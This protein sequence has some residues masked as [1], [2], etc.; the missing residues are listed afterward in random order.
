MTFSSIASRCRLAALSIIVLLIASSSYAQD[1]NAH[2]IPDFATSIECASLATGDY[3]TAGTWSCNRVPLATDD[4]EIVGGH[5]VTCAS[6][7]CLAKVL[8]ADGLLVLLNNARLTVTTLQQR[9]TGVVEIGSL[10]APIGGVNCA[11]SGD[12]KILFRA[13]PLDVVANGVNSF[14]HAQYGN[15]WLAHGSSAVKVYGCEKTQK[16]ELT[17]DVAAGASSMPVAECPVNWQPGDRLVIADT[18]QLLGSEIATGNLNN[19]EIGGGGQWE[20]FDLV[21]CS[22]ATLTFNNVYSNVAGTYTTNA[23]LQYAHECAKDR[24]NAIEVSL[25]PH[26]EN[27]TRKVIFES[28]NPTTIDKVYTHAPGYDGVIESR[29]ATNERINLVAGHDFE[30]GGYIH[31]SGDSVIADGDY[32]VKKSG[33]ASDELE[34]YVDSR[35]TIKY[36]ITSVGTSPFG[37]IQRVHQ[38]SRRGHFLASARA[39]IDI[40]GVQFKNMGRTMSHGVDYATHNHTSQAIQDRNQARYCSQAIGSCTT[41]SD[42]SSFP[43]SK[44]TFDGHGYVQGVGA[45]QIGRYAIHMHKP[46]GPVASDISDAAV[47]Y[48]GDPVIGR[49]VQQ[50]ALIN[51]VI[52]NTREAL[53]IH[54]SRWGI[55]IHGTSYGLIKGNTVYNIRGA[56]I[57]FEDGN[58]YKNILD[59]NFVLRVWGLDSDRDSD[60]DEPVCYYFR[61]TGTYVRNNTCA[62]ARPGGKVNAGFAFKYFLVNIAATQ[63]YSC[64]PGLAVNTDTPVGD[65]DAICEAGETFATINPKLVPIL[66]FDGNEGYGLDSFLTY[67]HVGANAQTPYADELVTMSY[68]KNSRVWNFHTYVIYNYHVNKLTLDGAIVRGKYFTA[69]CP[70]GTQTVMHGADYVARNWTLKNYNAQNVCNFVDAHWHTGGVAV[71]FQN[72][73]VS[74]NWFL[75]MQS[76]QAATINHSDIPPRVQNYRNNTWYPQGT[77]PRLV[78][79]Q[80]IVQGTQRTSDKVFFYDHTTD[81]VSKGNF[82]AYFAL[83]KNDGSEIMQ[84]SRLN[85]LPLNARLEAG[86]YVLS[87]ATLGDL[88]AGVSTS[89]RLS[90]TLPAGLD[91][92]GRQV[93]ID[94]GVNGTG[95]DT[96]EILTVHATTPYVDNGDGTTTV[97]FTTAVTKNHS[98]A[99]YV[100][101][102]MP[103]VDQVEMGVIPMGELAPA[104]ATDACAT[105]RLIYGGLCRTFIVSSERRRYRIRF[106]TDE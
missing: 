5:V 73:V 64:G 67:W 57:M 22:G 37:T 74:S 93:S 91:I 43:G 53:D 101:F 58:E 11:S 80:L 24:F 26:V 99:R 33:L 16:V 83:Q 65:S 20:E 62:N 9:N 97:N 68:V 76:L 86:Y 103:V 42:N 72:N 75:Q 88:A 55:A 18:R 106:R 17:G 13:D 71:E 51:N 14:D 70:T 31:I 90:T 36:D 87:H 4:V 21:S 78:N 100:S 98:D 47:D 96:E 27:L 19:P 85:H 25:C 15:G 7:A 54:P 44:G 105:D 63:R 35:R 28:E 69:A 1:A 8:D 66:E 30:D 59:G 23:T 60:G 3:T 39:M 79:Y 38:Y 34:L 41:N 84:Y 40:R 52:W 46:D 6:T 48:S 102:T 89:V 94:G 104:D 82:Q 2:T 77:S 56:G 10:S 49:G 61:G 92:A 45:N 32:F 29:D 81:G 12:V 95:D 50:F